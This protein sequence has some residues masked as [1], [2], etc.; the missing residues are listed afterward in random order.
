M[1]L[2]MILIIWSL[3]S[4]GALVLFLRL[5]NRAL[6]RLRSVQQ[7]R[8]KSKIVL[9]LARSRFRSEVLWT[10][11]YFI[12][13]LVSS[14][15]TISLLPTFTEVSLNPGSI[16]IIVL[17]LSFTIIGIIDGLL[18]EYDDHQMIHRS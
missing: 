17:V 16:P 13:F 9:V 2:L 5:T 6:E 11:G 1:L 18:D 7:I 12:S 4:L 10:I 14:F 3:T 8:F 15:Y